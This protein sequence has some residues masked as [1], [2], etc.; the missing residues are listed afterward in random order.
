MPLLTPIS[1]TPTTAN[2]EAREQRAP[3]AEPFDDR[4]DQRRLIDRGDA[5]TSASVRP[6]LPVL[7]PNAAMQ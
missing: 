4:T 7:H 3:F 1:A 2:D 5:P 6:M